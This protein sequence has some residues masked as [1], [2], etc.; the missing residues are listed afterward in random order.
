MAVDS[1]HAE[2]SP[3]PVSLPFARPAAE[4][5]TGGVPCLVEGDV[6]VTIDTL[7]WR[8]GPALRLTVVVKAAFT[9]TPGRETGALSPAEAPRFFPADVHFRNQPMAHPTAASDRVP[10]KSRVDVTLLGHAHAP[11]GR[12]APDVALSFGALHAGATLFQ[13]KAR[14]VGKRKAADAA[15]EPFAR[16]PVVYER[17]YG[18]PGTPTNP[19]GCGDDEDDAPPNIVDPD[20][21]WRPAAFGPLAA[22]WPL[23]HRKL[24]DLPRRALDAAIVELPADFDMSY[25]QS[26][27]PDQ[28]LASL[29]P[30]ISFVLE[31]FH[32]ER[33][34]IEVATPD[35]H[36]A[37]VVYGLST[38]EPDAATSLSFQLD[39]LHIDADAWVCT[40]VWRAC[41]DLP[42]EAARGRLLV[43]AGVS[44]GGEELAFL[45]ERPEVEGGRATM[46]D[47]SPAPLARGAGKP[48]PR[49]E[50]GTLEIGGGAG[51]GAALPFG[52]GQ[53]GADATMALPTGGAAALPITPF[54]Q[55][56]APAPPP[57][58]APAPPALS[59]P[60]VPSA[61][62][63]ALTVGLPISAPPEP[64]SPATKAEAPPP[65]TAPAPKAAPAS[66]P[67][68]PAPADGG[69]PLRAAASSP[70][71][72]AP[73]VRRGPR[74]RP[75]GAPRAA[76]PPRDGRESASRP[77]A[78]ERETPAGEP[79]GQVTPWARGAE[80]GTESLASAA[81]PARN[82]RGERKFNLRKGFSRP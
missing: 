69:A 59:A 40:L 22:G 54:A 33:P 70:A 48:L 3:S 58:P 60:A 64:A 20:N 78:P 43:A 27:P 1:R 11:H 55:R 47:L 28:Q 73:A 36:A 8:A 30:G 53:S 32:P 77:E 5:G 76:A 21:A 16:M 37:G 35:A 15:P 81:T 45:S 25:F 7:T 56:A 13:K 68:E 39:T 4:G 66:P 51:R 52:G 57:A 49:A 67:V 65:P 42:D 12:P 75:R 10:W 72:P 17:A 19:I 46:I 6:P 62:A 31:G 41:L 2:R 29:G 50:T 14:A 82:P 23:R 26:A 71:S 63:P 74:P 18:G 9:I 44:V 79:Y 34:R 61:P 24:R 80:G 38:A